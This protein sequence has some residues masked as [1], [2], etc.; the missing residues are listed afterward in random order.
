VILPLSISIKLADSAIGEPVDAAIDVK[1]I[2]PVDQGPPPGNPP[3]RH[4]Q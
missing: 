1:I 2:G 3:R 4:W